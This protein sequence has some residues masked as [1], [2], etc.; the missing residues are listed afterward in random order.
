MQ[1]TSKQL[2]SLALLVTG[3][4]SSACGIG[5]AEPQA[6]ATGH[7]LPVVEG[8][9]T[10]GR[11]LDNPYTVENMTRAYKNL[12]GQEPSGQRSVAVNVRPTHLY[13]RLLPST[14]EAYETLKADTTLKLYETPLDYEITSHGW[15]Y[16]DP[17]IPAHLPTWQYTAVPATYA[18][19]PGIRHEVL[20]D[21]YIPEQDPALAGASAA[22]GQRAS[23]DEFVNALLNEAMRLTGN[24]EDVAEPTR[25]AARYNPSGTVRV[26]DTR[27]QRL[28]PLEGVKVRARRWFN[29]EE[30][31][32][33]ANG[34]FFIGERFDRPVNYALFY[35]RA[36]FDIRSGTFGQAWLDGPKQS[37]PWNVDLWDG[38]QRFYATILR[39]AVDYYYGPRLNLASPPQ[40]TT[41]RSALK[42]AAY[43]S[44]SD[45][46]GQTHPW[47]RPLGLFSS[48]DLY[49]P[50]NPSDSIYGTTIHELAHYSHWGIDN[51]AY[52]F[53]ELKVCESWARGVQW[54]LTN[55]EYALLGAQGYDH[56]S[57]WQHLNTSDSSSVDHMRKGY[58]PVVIDLMDTVNQRSQNAGNPHFADDR[59][60]GFTLLEIERTLAG[61]RGMNEWKEK[62]KTL[63]RVPPQDLDAL[64]DFYRDI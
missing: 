52:N 9:I 32:T 16:H 31:L 62:L 34:N 48:I 26:F 14:W 45:T 17:S 43:D 19:H 55:Q 47:S 6:P 8:T 63:G 60:S 49:N 57:G 39:A 50:N 61:T 10:L 53:C 1:S 21:L 38:T 41:W 2:L 23:N 46:N 56:F 42:I 36:D 20:A 64:F 35:E 51:N 24:L 12:R 4:I 18:F 29:I 7:P 3:I 25:S 30:V 27:L 58:T 33:D 13:V 28:I 5:E 37:G 22:A 44:S 40:K 59:V 54:A 11:R 15:R